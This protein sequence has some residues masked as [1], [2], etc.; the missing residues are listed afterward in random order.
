MNVNDAQEVCGPHIAVADPCNL[1]SAGTSKAAHRS[2]GTYDT[3]GMKTTLVAANLTVN[4]PGFVAAAT[5]ASWPEATR[6]PPA[7]TRW[8]AR[9]ERTLSGQHQC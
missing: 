1:M 2:S 5:G 4:Q 9:E 8:V 3:G 6:S 7:S